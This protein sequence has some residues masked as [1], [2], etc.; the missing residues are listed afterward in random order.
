MN[1]RTHILKQ[2]VSD[3]HYVV[4][5][6]LVAE[7]ILLRARARAVVPDLDFNGTAPPMQPEPRLRSFRRCRWARSFRLAGSDQLA[8]RR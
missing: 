1:A 4:D 5:E 2:L 6:A 3:S 8:L 7:S